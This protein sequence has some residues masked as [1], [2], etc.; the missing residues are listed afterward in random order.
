MATVEGVCASAT[1][2]V[3]PLETYGSN[4][5][6]SKLKFYKW[7]QKGNSRRKVITGTRQHNMA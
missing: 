7:K 5:T 2:F 1:L 3:T 6:Y 4:K